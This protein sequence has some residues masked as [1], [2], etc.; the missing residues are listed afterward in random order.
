[1]SFLTLQIL[2]AQTYITQGK[3][4]IKKHHMDSFILLKYY[5]V[6]SRGFRVIYMHNHFYTNYILNVY[7][8]IYLVSSQVAYFP[9]STVTKIAVHPFHYF[10]PHSAVNT[11]LTAASQLNPSDWSYFYGNVFNYQTHRWCNVRTAYP[12]FI[13]SQASNWLDLGASV[14]CSTFPVSVWMT[15]TGSSLIWLFS[16]M[17]CTNK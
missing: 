2:H 4:N 8:F 10:L 7:V 12:G 16:S 11:W 13:S 1:M 15:L 3:G 6:L 14:P 17:G 5:C 9:F